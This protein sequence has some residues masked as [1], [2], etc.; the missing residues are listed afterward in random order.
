MWGHEAARNDLL[1]PWTTGQCRDSSFL[2]KVVASIRAWCDV[3]E[4]VAPKIALYFNF[5]LPH[6][7]L[8]VRRF[9]IYAPEQIWISKTK[10]L[11]Q[12][13]ILAVL[14]ACVR[15]ELSLEHEEGIAGHVAKV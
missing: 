2:A 7:F 6:N 5:N 8:T 14:G 9:W 1:P 10:R 11:P 12:R 13:P 4:L 3:T 15:K